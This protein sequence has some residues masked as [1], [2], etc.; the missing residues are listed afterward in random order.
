MMF[1]YRSDIGVIHVMRKDI[2]FLKR[3]AQ[4]CGRAA[5]SRSPATAGE[6][7]QLARLCAGAPASLFRIASIQ[8]SI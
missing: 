3:F 6:C 5:L 1:A 8:S 2:A 7:V 4:K